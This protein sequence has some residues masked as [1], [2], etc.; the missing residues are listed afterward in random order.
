MCLTRCILTMVLI[1]FLF[2]IINNF[3][4]NDLAEHYVGLANDA[5]FEEV[6]K[7]DYEIDREKKEIKKCDQ[8]GCVTK[9]YEKHFN[10]P[11]AVRLAKDKVGTSSI[12]KKH[13]IP[14]PKFTKIDIRPYSIDVIKSRMDREGI[15]YP[16]VIKP[17]HGTFG[18]DVET[19]IQS[20][21]ELKKLLDKYKEKYTELM[22]EEQIP[23]DCY[24]I[25]IFNNSIIDVI[26]R[27]KPFIIG[28][29][30]KTVQQLIDERNKEQIE[31]GFFETKNVSELFMKKQGVEGLSSVLPKGKKVYISNVINMH[32]G[33]RISRIPLEDI[34]DVN[35]ELF[36]RVNQALDIN[37][38]GLDYL[39]EDITVPFTEN[40]GT[41]LE[42]NGTPDTDIH[43]K[44]ENEHF[45]KDIVNNIF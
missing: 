38:S 6:K 9:K 26:Q 25:F 36:L 13:S 8:N 32:N 41:I 31:K 18:I 11:E 44:I 27:E 20:D 3:L 42:V 40:R 14:I 12:L 16:V 30:T 23:G 37:C 29:G 10:T 28:D 24:R 7:Q 1:I 15:F 5:F 34:P 45:F 17:I 22:M 19:D 35:K 21:E 43:Q 4:K 33:A 39:S 2:Y